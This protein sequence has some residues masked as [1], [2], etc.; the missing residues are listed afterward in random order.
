MYKE[1]AV[2]RIYWV[3]R[4][5]LAEPPQITVHQSQMQKHVDAASPDSAKDTEEMKTTAN[6]HE[7]RA[8]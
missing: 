2:Q 6:N 5:V 7:V 1:E 3:H 4:W 8:E